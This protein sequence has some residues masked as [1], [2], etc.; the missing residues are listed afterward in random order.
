[1]SKSSVGY[2]GIHKPHDHTVRVIIMAV[3]RSNSSKRGEARRDVLVR[4]VRNSQSKR[5]LS[6]NHGAKFYWGH[7]HEKEKERREECQMICWRTRVVENAVWLHVFELTTERHQGEQTVRLCEWFKVKGTT[8]EKIWKESG[9]WI[10]LHV[11]DGAGLPYVTCLE[12]LENHDMINGRKRAE[13]TLDVHETRV[14]D[15][16]AVHAWK[17]NVKR[18]N[19]MMDVLYVRG[20][21]RNYWQPPPPPPR[22]K[23]KDLFINL[24]FNHL[25][26][27][28]VRVQS[29][30]EPFESVPEEGKKVNFW[31]ELWRRSYTII[32]FPSSQ[33]CHFPTCSLYSV[34]LCMRMQSLIAWLNDCFRP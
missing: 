21:L 13:A 14:S 27:F 5:A 24:N 8:N 34:S 30:F 33:N 26:V 20:A 25:E 7:D 19:I 23:M 31:K 32:N 2:T 28:T 11:E 10:L 12:R 18:G 29:F 16:E 4:G 6:C 22:T 3:M 1:M 17:R 9:H 15:T